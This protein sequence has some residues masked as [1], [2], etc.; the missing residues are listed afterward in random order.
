MITEAWAKHRSWFYSAGIAA[1]ITVWLLSGALGGDDA[2]T[3]EAETV[4]TSIAAAQ[5]G[6]GPHPDGRGGR[7][8]DRR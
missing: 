2:D 7:T 3:A 4:A 8:H 5:Q 1:L 6:A